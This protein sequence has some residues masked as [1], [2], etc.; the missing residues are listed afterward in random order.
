MKKP[1]ILFV[2]LTCSLSI[3]AQELTVIDSTNSITILPKS[4]RASRTSLVTNHNTAIGT[5]A[6]F[7]NNSGNYNTAIGFNAGFNSVGNGNVFIGYNAGHSYFA[8]DLLIIR[9]RDS[10]YG[11]IAGS[12]AN[13]TVGIN[14]DSPTANLH[15][16]S[17]S[18]STTFR[19]TNSVVTSTAGLSLDLSGQNAY[20]LNGQ[21]L[22]LLSLGANNHS[23]MHFTPAGKIGINTTAPVGNLDIHSDVITPAS[24]SFRLFNN[25]SIDRGF[26]LNLVNNDT[27]LINQITG[28][29]MNFYTEGLQRMTISSNGKIGIGTFS[30]ASRLD[31]RYNSDLTDAQLQ[32]FED[33]FDYARLRFK[34]IY[35]STTNQHWDIAAT[36]DEL[37]A[38]T[39]GDQLNFY[40][41]GRGD[42]FQIRGNGSACLNGNL[43]TTGAACT[44]DIRYKKNFKNLTNSLD[45]VSRMQGLYYF[46]KTDEFKEKGFTTDRQIG[47]IAQEVEQLFPELV[48][49]DAKGYKSVDY[50]RLTPVLVEA[51]KELKERNDLLE[52]KLNRIE[53]LLSENTLQAKK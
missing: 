53:K 42:I 36:V 22:G 5:G 23:V 34:N 41:N 11:L 44:S 8:N 39:A 14:T 21:P 52:Q 50:A 17:F 43:V 16:T 27:Y 31:I 7:G 3:C 19:I 49:T 30:P 18:E 51:I 12:F 45:K 29:N 15:V 4:I 9:G 28:G 32:L 6:L 1:L 37:A 25:S 46:W 48:S 47:F 2:L 38:S 24:A 40:L 33:E 20:I 10:N 35:S 13:K 26:Y